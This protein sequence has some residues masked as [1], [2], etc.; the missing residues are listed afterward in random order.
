MLEEDNIQKG[1]V[2]IEYEQEKP[3]KDMI[4]WA[5]GQS[6]PQKEE[7]VP[8]QSCLSPG[9]SM[10]SS[11]TEQVASCLTPNGAE[12]S[13]RSHQTRSCTHLT[14]CRT[15]NIALVRNTG[16]LRTCTVPGPG[17]LL[18]KHTTGG[19]NHGVTERT[20]RRGCP[21]LPSHAHTFALAAN[22]PLSKAA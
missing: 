7:K 5:V 22:H 16:P 4:Y 18:Q 19:R 3:P 21:D 6:P 2:K 10:H 9:R 17:R 1:D 15:G 14:D 11:P 8:R 12:R 20:Q 13:R